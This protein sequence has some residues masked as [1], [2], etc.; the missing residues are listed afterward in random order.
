MEGR[1]PRFEP[2]LPGVGIQELDVLAGEADTDLHTGEE[3]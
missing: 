3:A 1:R 2:L